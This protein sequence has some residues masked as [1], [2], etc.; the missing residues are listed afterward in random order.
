MPGEGQ[1]R[2]GGGQRC[3]RPDG[4]AET[5]LVR[6]NP[7]AVQT[8]KWSGRITPPALYPACR[9]A[10]RSNRR[11]A[12]L[13]RH[14]PVKAELRRRRVRAGAALPMRGARVPLGVACTGCRAPLVFF[15]GDLRGHALGHAS[16]PSWHLQVDDGFLRPPHGGPWPGRRRPVVR[17]LDHLA[18]SPQKCA[19]RR[20]GLEASA[21]RG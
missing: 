8:T 18:A 2:C 20:E 16:G 19:R 7:A 11:P 10:V 12:H 21:R 13:R 1:P 5:G 4:T 15:F 9:E 3:M 14:R 6:Y 17:G